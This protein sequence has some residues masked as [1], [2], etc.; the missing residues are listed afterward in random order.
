MKQTIEVVR[1]DFDNTE[2]AS[3]VRFGL[4]GR[5]L[6][7]DLSVAREKKLRDVLAP[8]VEKARRAGSAQRR[9]VARSSGNRA[10]AA[11]SNADV[12]QWAMEQGYDVSERGRISAEVIAA[13]DAEH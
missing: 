7:I 6:E 3:T 11:R 9:V 13:Y 5:E 4:D 10:A 8:Y 12:R 2:G 1:C